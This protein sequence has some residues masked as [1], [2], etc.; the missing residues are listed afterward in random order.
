M[1]LVV[2]IRIY[3]L[4]SYIILR[5]WQRRKIKINKYLGITQAK[6][7]RLTSI[8]KIAVK[9]VS[10]WLHNACAWTSPSQLITRSKALNRNWLTVPKKLIAE[11]TLRTMRWNRISKYCDTGIRNFN[12]YTKKSIVFLKSE[13]RLTCLVNWKNSKL[14]EK[15]KEDEHSTQGTKNC[16]DCCPKHHGSGEVNIRRCT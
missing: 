8:S 4:C 12:S 14:L 2:S 7:H 11:N 10:K 15:R 13:S 6:V 16:G 5:I 1:V 9:C 3:W